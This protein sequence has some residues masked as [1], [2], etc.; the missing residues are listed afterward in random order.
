MGKK[1]RN[2][3]LRK[4]IKKM[5]KKECIRKYTGDFIYVSPENSKFKN[6]V[7]S[8][9]SHIKNFFRKEPFINNDSYII[10]S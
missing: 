8:N 2:L 7:I 4:C 9:D 6:V 3:R 10:K 1:I 5:F